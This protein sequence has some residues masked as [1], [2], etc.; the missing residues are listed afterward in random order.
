MY[1]KDRDCNGGGVA[2]YV[3]ES[4]PE[5]TI[6]LTSNKLELI[7]LEVSPSYHA[8][9]FVI[10]C[11]YRPPTAGIDDTAFEN[12]REIPK[13]LDKEEKEI[14]L[15][16]DTNCDFKKIKNANAKK[17]KWIYSE[18]QLEQMIKSFTRVAITSTESGEKKVSKTLIDHFSSTNPKH[19]LVADVIR[20]GMVDRYLI[21]G[22]RKINAWRRKGNKRKVV[23]SR[24][25]NKYD[26]MLF[27]ND[28][29]Q[30]DWESILR[31]FDNDPVSMAATF[32]E[33]F[34]SILNLH[35]PVKKKRIRSQFAPWLTVSLKNLMKERDILK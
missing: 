26:K 12:L 27:R 13:N 10:V 22:I 5:P 35:A 29:E 7:A 4:L 18:Y 19:I 32:Q 24:N 9:P 15:I 21:Y 33:T 20:T 8:R 2:M 17:L 31:P 28:L 6:K 11:W 34:E 16:G 14:I 1:R 23:E 30:V 3:K 25:I